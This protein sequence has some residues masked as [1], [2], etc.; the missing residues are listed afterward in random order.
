MKRT[1]IAGFNTLAITDLLKGHI[2]PF[3]HPISFFSCRQGLKLGPTIHSLASSFRFLP[4][5]N[6]I[7]CW[8]ECGWETEHCPGRGK[9]GRL[10]SRGHGQCVDSPGRGHSHHRLHEGYTRITQTW[11][12]GAPGKLKSHG[13]ETTTLID[14]KH[15]RLKKCRYNFLTKIVIYCNVQYP[16]PS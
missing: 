9:T 7:G 10:R 13:S 16:V 4:P 11:H 6:R 12:P 15:C 5:G 14:I 8:A 3:A 1:T 2:A